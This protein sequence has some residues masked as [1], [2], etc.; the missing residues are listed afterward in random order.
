MVHVDGC[1]LRPRTYIA[2]KMEAQEDDASVDLLL[3]S[4]LLTIDGDQFRE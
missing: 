2:P 4:E 1:L 3:G